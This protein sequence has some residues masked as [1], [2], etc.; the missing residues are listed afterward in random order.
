MRV[1]KIEHPAAGTWSRDCELEVFH[2]DLSSLRFEYAKDSD[3]S[4]WKITFLNAVS[5][6]VTAEEFG[7]LIGI[8]YE[9][10]IEGAFYEIKNS[11]LIERYL[12]GGKPAFQL[13]HY[14]FCFYDEFIEVIAENFRFTEII[15]TENDDSHLNKPDST[16]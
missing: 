11:Q 13:K 7:S 6:Q 5:Y 15:Q 2:S 8:F 4:K 10:P 3:A 1:I 14:L 16:S 9:L 12:A